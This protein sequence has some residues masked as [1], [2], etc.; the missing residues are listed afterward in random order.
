MHGNY[1]ECVSKHHT[2]WTIDNTVRLKAQ[3]FLENQENIIYPLTV[4]VLFSSLSSF[5]RGFTIWIIIYVDVFFLVFLIFKLLVFLLVLTLSTVF[6]QL[7]LEFFVEGGVHVNLIFADGDWWSSLSALHF[8]QMQW[9]SSVLCLV[10]IL[11]DHRKVNNNH[12]F[13]RHFKH[14]SFFGGGGG[15]GGQL[16]L[17]TFLWTLGRGRGGQFT[18]WIFDSMLG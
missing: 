14:R 13:L 1:K 7:S 16:S 15:G 10:Y 11:Q 6:R 2:W 17:F 4:S 12:R 5:F 3:T 9:T 18:W 8:M